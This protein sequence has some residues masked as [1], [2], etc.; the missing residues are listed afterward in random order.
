MGRKWSEQDRQFLVETYG[1]LSI[2]EQAARLGRTANSITAARVKLLRA[3]Q[4]VESERKCFR[5]WTAAEDQVLIGLV[6][7]LK[8]ANAIFAATFT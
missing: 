3:G 5:L 2:L 7:G 8:L 6:E 4:I 1:T